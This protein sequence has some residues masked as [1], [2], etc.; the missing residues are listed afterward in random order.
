VRRVDGQGRQYREDP[1]REQGSHAVLL[2]RRQLVPGEDLDA[3]GGQRGADLLLEDTR[4]FGDERA[5]ALEQFGVQLAGHLAGHLRHGDARGDAA[6]Q[7]GDADHEE[8]VEV[9][10]E[11]REELGALDQ[12]DATRVL[13]Q[14][15][16]PVVEVEPALFAVEVAVD[17]QH[18]LV[19]LRDL[20]H[21]LTLL[22][23]G[24]WCRPAW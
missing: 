2:R 24:N 20:R 15:E 23:C 5:D 10:G 19:R 6:L 3:L 12:G 7:T 11:D 9:G 14:V 17:G 21:R 8:L 18:G 4:L 22:A 16:D 1:F 13:R